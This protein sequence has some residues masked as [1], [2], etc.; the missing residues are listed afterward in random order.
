MRY[1]GPRLRHDWRDYF[2][3]YGYLE[4]KVLAQKIVMTYKLCSERLSSQK[5]YDCGMRAVMSV[6]RAAA[7]KSERRKTKHS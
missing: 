2:I 3:L 1:D 6:L 7:H 4:G 5:H